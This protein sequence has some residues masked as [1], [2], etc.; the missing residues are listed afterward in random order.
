MSLS[1]ENELPESSKGTRAK[2]GRHRKL[3]AMAA[4]RAQAARAMTTVRRPAVYRMAAGTLATAGL[5]ALPLATGAGA[6]TS[7]VRL[8]AAATKSFVGSTQG[9]RLDGATGADNALTDAFQQVKN[10][11]REARAEEARTRAKAQ[12]Q[13]LA[14]TR[15]QQKLAAERLAKR[16]AEIEKQ[17][18]ASRARAHERKLEQRKAK[19]GKVLDFVHDQFDE[20]YVW[21]GIGPNGWDCS[22]ITMKAYA[23]VGVKTGRTTWD[24]KDM[25]AERKVA[26]GDLKPGDLVFF[27]NDEHMGI[28]SRKGYM[29]HAPRSGDVVREERLGAKRHSMFTGAVRPIA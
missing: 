13:S 8:S 6:D 19:I 5:V 3:S 25:F 14:Q 2:G 24:Q 27:S 29:Y 28:V 4:A 9:V 17:R 23:K 22:G 20:P 26:W 12:A 21:G 15:A 1:P 10:K 16:E 18:E 11:A 7:G